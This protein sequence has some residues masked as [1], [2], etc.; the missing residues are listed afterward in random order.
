MTPTSRALRAACALAWSTCSWLGNACAGPGPGL[1]GSPAAAGTVE[2]LRA[3]ATSV[4]TASLFRR[5]ARTSRSPHRLQPRNEATQGTLM[6][7]CHIGNTL[8]KKNSGHTAC[9][10]DKPHQCNSAAPTCDTT[11]TTES[12]SD[13][14]V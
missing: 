11:P 1:L 13:P 8:N 10:L 4:T 2:T 6:R 3:R 5:T 9:R 12:K 14:G 7:N